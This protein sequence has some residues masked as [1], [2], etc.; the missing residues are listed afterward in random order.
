MKV[1]LY[2]QTGEILGSIELAP[3]IFAVA[4]IRPALIHEVVTTMQANSRHSIASTKTRGEVRG[5]G[6]KPWQQK[7][8]GRARAGS[9][10]SPLWRGGG[11]TFGPRSQRNFAKKINRKVKSLA[12]FSVFSDKAKEKKLLVLNDFSLPSAKTRELAKA[13]FN[14]LDKVAA[15]SKKVVLIVT[16]TQRSLILAGRNL[17]NLKVLTTASL[18]LLELVAAETVIVLKDAVAQIEKT[19]LD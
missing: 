4:K 11:I 19:Y 5:G 18:N 7:G 6:K 2:S 14:F 15:P 10:R 3:K 16:P 9:I 12:L 1:N 13:V 8:T 17:K